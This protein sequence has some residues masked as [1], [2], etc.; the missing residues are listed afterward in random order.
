MCRQKYKKSVMDMVYCLVISYINYQHFK[1]IVLKFISYQ[2]K[3]SIA[4]FKTQTIFILIPFALTIKFYIVYA[5]TNSLFNSTV[6]H[7]IACDFT[8][9]YVILLMSLASAKHRF[10]LHHYFN[11]FP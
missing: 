9:Q 1:L 3:P 8:L 5:I 4:N 10:N 6:F 7:S 11:Y 2:E